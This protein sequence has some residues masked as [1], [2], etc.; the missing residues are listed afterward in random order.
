[1]K[2]LSPLPNATTEAISVLKSEMDEP[3]WEE[4]LLQLMK[5]AADN[6]KNIWTLI[7]Q[8]MR[9]ADSGRLSWGYH[10]KILSGVVYILSYVGDS[11]SY[12]VLLN[13]VKSLD[14][15]IPIGAMEL[16]SDLLPTFQELDVKELF[17]IAISPDELK[18]AFAVMALSKLMYE[19]RLTEDE[20]LNFKEF[21]GTYKNYKYYLDDMIESTL[22]FL[23]ES[24]S[25]SLIHQLDGILE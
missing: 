18:S 20:K 11:K 21:L 17:T 23:N 15:S 4:R 2:P 14:R 1:M 16:I 19:N 22:E 6:D 13:Y 10:K 9:D 8:I 25:P 24:N 3:Y 12:R 5:L 7:Y